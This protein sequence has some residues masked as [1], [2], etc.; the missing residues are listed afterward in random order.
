MTILFKTD[1][2]MLRRTSFFAIVLLCFAMLGVSACKERKPTAELRDD[3]NL[4]LERCV[5]LR[6][7]GTHIVAHATGLARLTSQ[8]GV[9]DA[10]AG[11]S[12]ATIS[13]FIYESMLMNPG[14]IALTQ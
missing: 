12:S 11:G 5:A 2:S 9:I 1:L 6:G 8:W 4:R 14:V 3:K 7:N 10:I 13:T